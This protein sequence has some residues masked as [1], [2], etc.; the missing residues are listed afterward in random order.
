MA[1]IDDIYAVVQIAPT[2]VPTYVRLSQNENGRRMYFAI[3]GGTIPTGSTATVSGTKPDGVVY[4]ASGTITGN[5]VLINEDVQLTAVAGQWDAKLKIINS[6]QTIA[7]GRI[8]FVIDGDT[9]APGSVPSDSQLEGLV[10]EA[11]SYAEAA[12]NAAFYGSPLMAS[13]VADMTDHTRV[14]VYT[15]SESGYTN[16]NWYYWNGTAWTSGGVYNAVAVDTDPSLTIAGKAAD[17]RATGNRMTAAETDIADIKS[18]LDHIG[19]TDSVKTALLDCFANVAWTD[20]HGQE[21]YDTLETALYEGEYPRLTA[22]FAPGTHVVYTDDD[23]STLKP[24]LSVKLYQ[25]ADDPGT[26]ISPTD[27]TLSGTLTEG[28][29]VVRVSY[30]DVSTT[31]TLT[32][33]DFYNIMEWTSP[34]LLQVDSLSAG[35][36]NGTCGYSAPQTGY[37]RR[38]V[39]AYRGKTGAYNNST[40]QIDNT[41]FPIPIPSSATNI[42]LVISSADNIYHGIVFWE[43]DDSTGTYSKLSDNGWSQAQNITIP[44]GKYISIN[45]KNGT[46]GN[47]DFTE[48][49][50][51][52]ITYS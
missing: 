7:T 13:T 12:K 41:R 22:D 29:S 28:Q 46:T 14:Y 36:Y 25:S 5:T 52:T 39:W 47:T 49:P 4:S 2:G 18:D 42:N 33:V 24:Y 30:N 27:Y 11:Q 50:I 40:Q 35:R 31:F 34:E 15:G 23:L 43:Y 17:A 37:P 21:Y 44:Q 19:L 51:V 6:G 48:T 20:E 3:V 45:M 9:V 16:G 32:A 8:R 26:V 10:A 1:Y 38:S